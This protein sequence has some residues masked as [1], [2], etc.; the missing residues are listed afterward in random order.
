MRQLHV[1]LPVAQYAKRVTPRQAECLELAHLHTAQIAQVLDISRETVRKHLA[2][3][4][5][6]LGVENRAQA[7]KV[8]M[9]RA[10]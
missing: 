3:A 5:V 8:W 10:A 1:V 6:K 4:Y 9:G 7:Q 2:N